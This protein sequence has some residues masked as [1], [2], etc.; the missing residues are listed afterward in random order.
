GL[1][2][3][4]AMWL[5]WTAPFGTSAALFAAALL[6]PLFHFSGMFLV[7]GLVAL[8]IAGARHRA[9]ALP[10]RRIAGMLAAV[11]VAIVLCRL[12]VA[13]A[14]G[15]SMPA[16]AAGVGL[17]PDVLELLTQPGRIAERFVS[18]LLVPYAALAVAPLALLFLR[19]PGSAAVV[20]AILLLV[21]PPALPPMTK[22][23]I[24]GQYQLVTFP[25]LAAA[26]AL[27]LA[28]VPRRFLLPVVTVVAL[29]HGTVSTLEF[30]RLRECPDRDWAD[31]VAAHTGAD[32]W[33]ICAN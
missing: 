3:G 4:L 11:V 26:L 20:I 24:E 23:S 12:I 10:P 5:A 30:R 32:D 22:P 19:P 2:A 6:A 1:G 13:F 18:E 25:A 7:P 9:E 17:V 29:A 31:A 33:V 21:V 28:A 14:M 27:C 15:V 16:G 8:A